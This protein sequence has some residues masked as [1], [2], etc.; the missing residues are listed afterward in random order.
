MDS[1]NY[2]FANYLKQIRTSKKI[3]LVELANAAG[4]SNS[5]LSQ[6]ENSKRNP[7]KP[8][9][10]KNIAK[11]LSLNNPAEEKEIYNQLA[12]KAGYTIT[13]SLIEA[14]TPKVDDSKVKITYRGDNDSL[15][16]IS[17]DFDNMDQLFNLDILLNDDLYFSESTT[18]NIGLSAQGKYKIDLNYK[19][20]DLSSEQKKT[21]RYLLE[22]MHQAEQK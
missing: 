17:T 14:F 10:L 21:L 2:D 1:K 19:G 3:T 9:L 8:E 7:P 13:G 12:K 11:G 5:Y 15:N 6:L 20:S 4:T 16:I 18:N 22:G